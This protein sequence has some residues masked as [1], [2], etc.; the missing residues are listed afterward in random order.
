MIYNVAIL[1][2]LLSLIGFGIAVSSGAANSAKATFAGGCFWCMEPP[3]EKQAGVLEVIS[4]YTGGKKANPT[5]KEVSSGGTGHYEAIQVTFDPAI[6][7]YPEL[8]DIFFKQIDPTDTGG[9]FADRG[10]QYRT[11]IFYHDAEQKRVAEEAKAKLENSGIFK[12]KIAVD[13]IP[14]KE[15]YPA[16]DYHQDYYKK[17]PVHYK[18]YKKGSG[19]EDFL[20]SRWK[21]KSFTTKEVKKEPEFKK[22]AKEELKKK[23]DPVCYNVTQE[24][25]TERPFQNAYWDNKKDGIYVDAVSGEPLFS[26]QDKFDSGTG[27][28]SFTKPIEPSNILELKDKSHFMVRTEVRSRKGDSHLG[29]IFDDGPG[30][31]RLRYCINSA[32]LRFIPKEDLEKEGYAQYIK[33]FDR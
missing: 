18:S 10:S 24:N 28:P 33:L 6:V 22:P 23:L 30:P 7:L 21:G 17:E 1:T 32:S 27:W 16:E 13:I 29:H 31:T 3:F 26:S 9:Q 2:L 20:E 19:R 25:G 4:G 8:V 11:A 14:A 15:F 5:Y 12:E